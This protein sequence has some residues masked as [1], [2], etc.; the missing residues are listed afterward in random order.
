VKS[1]KKAEAKAKVEEE[2]QREKALNTNI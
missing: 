2:S 1:G